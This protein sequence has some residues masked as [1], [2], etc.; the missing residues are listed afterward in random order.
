MD[1][2]SGIGGR[3]FLISQ[4]GA[5]PCRYRLTCEDF[6]L[7]VSETMQANAFVLGRSKALWLNGAKALFADFAPWLAGLGAGLLRPKKLSPVDIPVNFHVPEVDVSAAN[8]VSRL[9]KSAEARERQGR[10]TI[11]FGSGDVVVPIYEKFAEIER[12]SGELWLFALSCS[13]AGGWRVEVQ[14]RG[15]AIEAVLRHAYSRSDETGKTIERRRTLQNELAGRKRRLAN[16]HRRMGDERFEPDDVVY[17]TV[18]TE[19]EARSALIRQI[20]ALDRKAEAPVKLITPDKVDALVRAVAA[21][22]RDDNR[23]QFARAYIQ[24]VVSEVSVT[25][26]KVTLPGPNAALLDQT[27]IRA[28]TG[29]L[30][31]GFAREWRTGEDSNPRPPDS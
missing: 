17:A 9:R 14:R 6:A 23:P 12:A 13:E 27:S 2:R 16:L 29:E 11:R 22:L 3:A 28:D 1:R 18:K 20:A 19:Q 7:R 25:L 5:Y 21:V 8:I 30:V 4:S 15:D 31:P 24:T 26:E 10:Q